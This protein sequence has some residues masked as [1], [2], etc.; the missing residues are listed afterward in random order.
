MAKSAGAV[1]EG[2]ANLAERLYVSPSES[3]LQRH[4]VPLH[5][6]GG[7][8]VGAL[9]RDF[10]AHALDAIVDRIGQPTSY[11]GSTAGPVVRWRDVHRTLLLDSGAEGLQLS[12]RRTAALEAMERASF[13]GTEDADPAFYYSRLPYLWQLYLEGTSDELPPLPAVPRAPDWSWL[14]ESLKALLDAWW[15]QLPPQIGQDTAGFNIVPRGEHQGTFSTLSVLC[16]QADG[17][18]L[19]VDDRE[20][21]GGTPREAMAGRGWHDRT[22]GWWQRDFY[23]LGPEGPAAAARMAVEEMRLRGVRSPED[24]ATAE[25]RCE[26]GGQL[27]LPG[28]ALRPR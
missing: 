9:R 13:E 5:K 15:E 2:I 14:K 10:T 4:P 27:A 23:D 11:G 22:M 18:L 8:P 16:S 28:F 1:D 25:V 3:D 17:V 19:L 6:Y 7:A 12:V 21:P 26:G 24:L 20:V